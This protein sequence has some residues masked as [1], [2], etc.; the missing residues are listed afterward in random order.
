MTFS[1]RGTGTYY[2]RSRTTFCSRTISLYRGEP[3]ACWNSPEKSRSLAFGWQIL[4][5]SLPSDSG[6]TQDKGACCTCFVLRGKREPARDEG[7][8]ATV[9]GWEVQRHNPVELKIV[10][11]VAN[12]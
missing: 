4:E 3:P 1:K 10:R 8:D 2:R 7:M 11:V 5:N 9:Y 6:G 12:V